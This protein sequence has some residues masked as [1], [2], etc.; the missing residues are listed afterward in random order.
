L[1]GRLLAALRIQQACPQQ[2]Q[3]TRLVLVLAALVLAL[4]HDAGRQV[5]DAD[6]RLGLVDV[7]AAGAGG[8]VG[9]E[10]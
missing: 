8:T 1:R 10:A 9:V 6:R 5:G 4:D 7:L 3:R 2:A